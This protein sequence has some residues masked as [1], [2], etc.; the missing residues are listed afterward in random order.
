MGG[1]NKQGNV[2]IKDFIGGTAPS[3][4]QSF[5][6]TERITNLLNKVNNI[7]SIGSIIGWIPGYFTDAMN[8]GITS[9]KPG[10]YSEIKQQAYRFF[11]GKYELCDGSICNNIKSS[12]YS[13][14][15]PKIND[16]RFMMGVSSITGTFGGKN[17]IN[18]H[19]HG[20]P[21]GFSQWALFT[22]GAGWYGAHTHT[23]TAVEVGRGRLGD[24]YWLSYD[25]AWPYPSSSVD[26]VTSDYGPSAGA[27]SSYLIGYSHSHRNYGIILTLPE[28]TSNGGNLPSWNHSHGTIPLIGSVGAG[29]FSGDLGTS[30]HKPLFLTCIYLIK[31]E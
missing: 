21:G 27:G 30:D 24:H 20:N 29:P 26:W 5:T 11:G 7:V 25:Y 16:E 15:L 9:I 31:V 8:G 22:G 3:T 4:T 14:N 10:S 28:N 18:E 1:I 19:I 23:S 6:Y 12:W 17:K 13:K 2:F